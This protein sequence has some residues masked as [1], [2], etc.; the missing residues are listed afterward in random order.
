[1][2]ILTYN[3]CALPVF[4][5]DIRARLKRIG[6]EVA[7]LDPDLILLQEIFLPAHLKVLQA[8]LKGWPHVFFGKR[9]WRRHA[10]GLAIFSRYPLE[11]PRFIKYREQ[12]SWLRYSVLAKFS[13]KGYMSARLHGPSGAVFEL[14]H[15]HLIADYRRPAVAEGSRR[16]PYPKFQKGQIEELSRFVRGLDRSRPL[17]LAGDF[18]MPPHSKLLRAL[19]KRSG[20]RD[21]MEGVLEPSILDRRYYRLPYRP[22]PDKRLDYVFHRGGGKWTV[23]VRESRYVFK[24]AVQLENSRRVELSDHHG[25][26][27][28][29]KVGKN[30]R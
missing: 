5:G 9:S 18:N 12:G 13:G 17:L 29:L 24:G 10:G 7:A 22:A 11:S 4:A 21:G 6:L 8:R 2:R 16:D 27:T 23:D 30:G 1:M 19:L 20:L 3:C 26:L 28:E 15:T 14:V 25:V